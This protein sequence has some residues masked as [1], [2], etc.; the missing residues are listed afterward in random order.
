MSKNNLFV[1]LKIMITTC[2][3]HHGTEYVPSHNRREKKAEKEVQK[4]FGKN[5]L[6]FEMFYEKAWNEYAECLP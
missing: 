1:L 2:S 4:L 6:A 3:F 5:R